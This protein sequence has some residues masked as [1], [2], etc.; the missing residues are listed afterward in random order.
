MIKNGT[1]STDL[2]SV[3]NVCNQYTCTLM[4]LYTGTV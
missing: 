3:S 1:K 4:I 2:I